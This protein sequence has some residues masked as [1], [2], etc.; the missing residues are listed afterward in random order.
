VKHT[1]FLAGISLS[2]SGPALKGSVLTLSLGQV[3]NPLILNL[4]E[5]NPFTLV[6]D[7]HVVNLM[8]SILRSESL[9]LSFEMVGSSLARVPLGC[10][11]FC[12]HPTLSTSSFVIKGL[13]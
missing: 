6:S 11:P 3:Q 7:L 4:P 12:S 5:Y 1:L 8:W 2:P 9:S 10:L 13:L